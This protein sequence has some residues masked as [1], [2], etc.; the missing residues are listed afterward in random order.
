MHLCGTKFDLVESDKKARKVDISMA[1]E[2]AD[3]GYGVCVCMCVCVCVCGFDVC[4]CV[5]LCWC[6]LKSGAA[7]R[8]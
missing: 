7:L 1:K 8:K 3:G 2:Y 6:M 4:V 5:G